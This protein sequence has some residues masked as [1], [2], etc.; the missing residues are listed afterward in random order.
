MVYERILRE[1][2]FNRKYIDI[3]ASFFQYVCLREIGEYSS[4][5]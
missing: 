3:F 4:R 2:L 1:G 5:R